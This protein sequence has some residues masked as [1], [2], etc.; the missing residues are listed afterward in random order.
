MSN[1]FY[2]SN[3]N[4]LQLVHKYKIPV[5]KSRNTFC[6]TPVRTPVPPTPVNIDFCVRVTPKV[7]IKRKLSP[8]VFDEVSV[9]RLEDLVKYRAKY[10]KL[11]ADSFIN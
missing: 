8:I 5:K 9:N 3:K 11:M 6:L 1:S 2:E 10:K 7:R 4:F